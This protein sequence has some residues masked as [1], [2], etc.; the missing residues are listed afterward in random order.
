MNFVFV[1]RFRFL[2]LSCCKR[3]KVEEEKKKNEIYLN[4]HVSKIDNYNY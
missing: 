3:T 2:E 4:T 1:S